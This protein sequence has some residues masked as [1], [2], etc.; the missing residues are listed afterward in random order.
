VTQS[1]P[2]IPG[3]LSRLTMPELTETI[4]VS[5][6]AAERE[7]EAYPS[8]QP[9]AD[10]TYADTHR[11]PPPDW[12]LDEFTKAASGHGMT[13]TPYRGDRGVREVVAENIDTA[14]GLEV[15]PDENL[16]LTPGTQA[17][18]FTALDSVIEP[19]DEALLAD[20]DYLSTERMI[21]YFGARVTHIP[22]LHDGG[23]GISL[24]FDELEPA[25]K[26]R[27]KL[28]VFSNPNNPTGGVHSAASIH[29]IAEL[30][31][32]SGTTVLVDQLYCRL[33]YDGA[34]FH[35]LG[36]VRDVADRVITL[37][38][39]SK[40]ESMSGYR[41][42]LAVGPPQ[43]IDRMEDV[44]SV[45]ALRAPAYAQHIL[46]RWLCDD[47]D[48]LVRRIEEYQRLRNVTLETVAATDVLDVW[49]ARGTAYLFPRVLLNLSD[50]EVA[51]RLK[52]ECGL[53]VNPGYQ[54][55]PRGSGHFRICFA[56]DEQVWEEALHRIVVTLE[57][58]GA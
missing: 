12:V 9:V 52:K 10:L 27:P 57:A 21:R 53:V 46:K 3:R 1:V 48:F 15:D 8:G 49:P 34:T 30:V 45:S 6:R 23:G 22:L 58:L 33:L 47:G 26:R 42:G 13:Y 38:G 31:S 56:Q 7:L 5:L 17:G 50:Q 35:H 14:F 29:R 43:L 2:S 11:F 19:G 4:G 32:R 36:A 41:I 24:D 18:L 28:L 55:G 16:I 40:T 25:L 51:K 54:F 37:L 39:P 20:P 44:L